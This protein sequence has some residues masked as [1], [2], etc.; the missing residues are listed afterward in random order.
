MGDLPCPPIELAPRFSPISYTARSC[1]VDHVGLARMSELGSARD[2][3][4]HPI[5]MALKRVIGLISYP[6]TVPVLEVARVS[7]RQSA[8]PSLVGFQLNLVAMTTRSR[9]G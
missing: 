4:Q 2:E 1:L 7:L 3:Q 6:F 5:T 9:N 8:S